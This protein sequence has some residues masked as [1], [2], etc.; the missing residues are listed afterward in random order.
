MS[1]DAVLAI[2]WWSKDYSHL[3]NDIWKNNKDILTKYHHHF[4]FTIN[5]DA[6]TIL[7]PGLCSTLS[8]HYLQ[9]RTIVTICKDMD[10]DPNKSIM[11]LHLLHFLICVLGAR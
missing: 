5:G 2:S 6:N 4:T 1:P 3:L 7:E 8:Q 10:Q 11:A 9:L